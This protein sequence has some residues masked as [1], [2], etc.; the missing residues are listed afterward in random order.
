MLGWICD[1]IAVEADFPI[2]P[3]RRTERAFHDPLTYCLDP[4]LWHPDL[5]V[6]EAMRFDRQPGEILIVHSVGNY[7]ARTKFGR[8]LKGTG[9]VIAAVD[10]LRSEGIPARLVFKTG[11]ASR[12]MRF[13]QVQA[14]IAVDQ[15]V[16][17]RY[18]ATARECMMLGKPT[19]TYLV[20]EQP[21]GQPPSAAL[22][23]C[24]L[25]SAN[26]ERV[27]HALREL[28]LDADKRRAIGEAS[29]AYALKW[30]SA[31]AC[32]RRFEQ[33]YD[34]IEVRNPVRFGVT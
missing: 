29:R 17:G 9:A 34:N 14:D 21:F 1:L 15:L 18:G 23:E 32:A 10:R 7:D 31:D 25:V 13:Y 28:C 6:P 5:K 19:I 20:R 3:Y 26:E 30:H 22:R 4:N 16:Y 2:A 33:V 12:D 24:P 11:V 8:D 27:Y